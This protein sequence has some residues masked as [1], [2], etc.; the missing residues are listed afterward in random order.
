VLVI[1]EQPV[2]DEL[3][4]RNISVTEKPEEAQYVV[5]SWDRSFTYAK[6]NAAFQAWQKGAILLAT[7][8]DRTCPVE[9]G[10]LPDCGAIIG[11]LEGATGQP[12]DKVV[13]KP[14]PLMAEAALKQ[15]GLEAGRCYMIGD[16]L[17]TDI[18]MGNAAGMSSVLVLTGVTTQTMLRDTPFQPQHVVQ[19]IAEVPALP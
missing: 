16:R 8:P 5:L 11:A 14:S 19:S 1:G 3:Q 12:I 10:Q 7:N 13:G 2:L 6:L 9:G 18:K 17:E 4:R 15:I